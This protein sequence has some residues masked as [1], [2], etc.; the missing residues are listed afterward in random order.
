MQF[1]AHYGGQATKMPTEE[2]RELYFK[3]YTD[4]HRTPFSIYADLE[5][6][7]KQDESLQADE[8]S[9]HTPSGFAYVIID[10]KGHIFKP[11]VVYSGPDVIDEFFRRILGEKEDLLKIMHKEVSLKM[12]RKDKRDFERAEKCHLCDE[13]FEEG[14]KR[15]KNHDHPQGGTLA[16]VIMPAI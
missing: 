3:S 15:V 2:K 1:C 13:Y 5:C 12:T 7:L 11:P 8:L 6:F 14:E 16:Q 4:C 9:L 10:Y